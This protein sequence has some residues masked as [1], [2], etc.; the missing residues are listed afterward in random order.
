[1]PS[2]VASFSH[3]SH[4]GRK[5]G[6]HEIVLAGEKRH[7]D[8]FGVRV[9]V[10]FFP[11]SGAAGA[12]TV[13]AFYDGESLW[14]ARCYLTETGRWRWQS[15]CPDDS[16][17]DRCTGVFPVE[18]S[19]LRGMLRPH[20]ERAGHW[21]TDDGRWFLHLSDTAYHLFSGDPRRCTE[22][23]FR[24]YVAED[25][26]LGITSLRVGALGGHV[27]SNRAY[28]GECDRS[29]DDSNWPWETADPER[30]RFRLKKFQLTDARLIWMLDH[31][32]DMYIQLI[33]FGLV[34]WGADENGVEWRNLSPEIR[35]R[36]MD[37][38]IARW[39][40]F[41]QIFW[42]VVNDMHRFSGNFAF[43]DEVGRYFRAH[44]PWR[45]LLS[46]GFNRN[47]PFPAG[48]LK[49]ASYI[50]LETD[51]DLAA[52]QAR[53]YAGT[54]L[55][56]FNGEDRY[57]QDR[58]LK[59]PHDPAYFFRRLFLAWLLSGGS[60]CYGGRFS[61]T[62]PY[63]ATGQRPYPAYFEN[64]TVYNVRLSGL[65][66]VG[67]IGSFLTAKSIDLS[68]YLAADALASSSGAA[69]AGVNR[70][71][72]MKHPGHGYLVYDPNCETD[73]GP[74]ATPRP[75]RRPAFGVDLRGDAGVYAVEW[76][77]LAD[78]STASGGSVTGG[79]RVN[80]I[81]PWTGSDVLLHLAAVR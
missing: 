43:I 7:E 71:K 6:V 24:R 32:P 40:A 41:P 36:T 29:E 28:P 68:T 31:H 33:L 78:G 15:G 53:P 66:Q 38:M 19:L 54:G 35:R 46:A 59:N 51:Y 2:A 12:V 3:G 77:K 10:T 52:D 11:P 58:L 48:E 13:R 39:A 14:R 16:R 75:D 5:Y 64:D 1:M 80:F 50:H 70:L 62:D 34:R 61:R 4:P 21:R 44:D 65:D 63:S 57:E 67:L 37:Y 26:A 74:A 18:A 76:L 23:D 30:G 69:N 27:W 73:S 55:H 25:A 56:V 17:L 81:A 72:C 60:V 22:A 42:L 8:P 9:E 47:A 20:P 79:G 49:W 45:H